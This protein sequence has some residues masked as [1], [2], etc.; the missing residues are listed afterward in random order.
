MY[1]KEMAELS[2]NGARY[3]VIGGIEMINGEKE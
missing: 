1:E 2:K 3:L